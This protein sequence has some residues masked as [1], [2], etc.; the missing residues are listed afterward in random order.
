M[1]RRPLPLALAVLLV[2]PAA[3]ARAADRLDHRGA[4]GLSLG[5]GLEYAD[6]LLVQD[7]TGVDAARLTLDLSPTFAVGTEGNELVGTLRLLRGPDWGGAAG[8]AY[9]GY[10]GRDEV[11]TYFQGGFKLDTAPHWA[12]GPWA[13]FGLMYEL[14]PLV[15]LFGQLELSVEGGDGLRVG[16]G[17]SIGIQARTYLLE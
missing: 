12:V 8:F 2:W 14:S 3:S 17:G 15:G 6:V 16:G 4:R 1:I 7:R 10:F 13:Q 9:R 5:L 11:K